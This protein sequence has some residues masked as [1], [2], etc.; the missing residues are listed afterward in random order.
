MEAV[1]ECNYAVRFS[2]IQTNC[3][4]KNNWRILR[5]AHLEFEEYAEAC[6]KVK[7][8]K[9]LAQQVIRCNFRS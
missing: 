8:Y 7:P 3:K 5:A 9:H 4:V 2:K 1:Y 6:N